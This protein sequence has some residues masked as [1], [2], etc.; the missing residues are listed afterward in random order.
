VIHADRVTIGN[1]R[2][3]SVPCDSS[4]QDEND[5]RIREWTGV[6]AL[7]RPIMCASCETEVATE[8]YGFG[9]PRPVPVCP[10]C[11]PTPIHKRRLEL[12]PGGAA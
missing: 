3:A 1:G 5:E 4:P 7:A 6:L 11:S 2:L 9:T 10:G 8:I 12:V